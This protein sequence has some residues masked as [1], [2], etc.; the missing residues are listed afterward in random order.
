M[1]D[2]LVTTP[3]SEID[4]SKLEGELV[5][6]EGGYWFRTYKFMPKILSG[7]KIYFVENGFIKGYG[8]VLE[9]A[10]IKS[11]FIKCD[12]T[13]RKWFGSWILK[14]NDWHWLKKP[15]PHKGFQ[16]ILYLDNKPELK[17]RLREAE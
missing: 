13:E 8:I 6:A 15:V 4:N 11:T 9:V 10:P 1:S 7:Q 2:L 3:K 16:G 5:E 17:K 12:V 14:Y